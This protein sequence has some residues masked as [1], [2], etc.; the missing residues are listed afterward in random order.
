MLWFNCNF[1]PHFSGDRGEHVYNRFLI[2]SC[3]NVIPVEKRNPKLREELLKEKDIVSSVAVQFLKQAIDRGYKFTESER[4]KKNR[5]EYQYKNNSLEVFLKEC[6]TLGGGE[7]TTTSYFR[8]KYMSWCR[9][10]NFIP[11][12]TGDIKRILTEKYNV[13]QGKSYSEYY[14]LKIKD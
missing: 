14:E 1:P 2:L 6:C 13:V 4:T 7:R 3:E 5:E 10:N 8:Q 9:D 12:K 11:E